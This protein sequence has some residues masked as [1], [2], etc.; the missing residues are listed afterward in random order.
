VSHQ[1]QFTAVYACRFNLRTGGRTR[2][3]VHMR[4]SPERAV[5]LL[6]G[7]VIGKFQRF[8]AQDVRPL[9]AEHPGM[10]RRRRSS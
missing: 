10:M 2:G 6:P 7:S 4:S 9:I 8:N 5:K 1:G 3:R